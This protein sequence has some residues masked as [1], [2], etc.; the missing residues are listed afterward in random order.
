MSFGVIITISCVVLILVAVSTVLYIRVRREAKLISVMKASGLANFEAGDLD[1]LDPLLNLNDQADLLPYNQSFEF[2]RE[3]LKL[4]RKLGS[5]AFGVVVEAT[6][7][8]ILN[9]EEESTVAV[10]MVK[11]QAD[12]E[13]MKALVMELK[14]MV[15]LG[16]HLN[17]V[18]LLGA[19]TQNIVKRELMVIVEHCKFGNVQNFLIKNRHCFNSE[20][21]EEESQAMAVGNPE[22][23]ARYKNV[24]A[25]EPIDPYQNESS[26]TTNDGNYDQL[27]FQNSEHR[28]NSFS[29]FSCNFSFKIPPEQFA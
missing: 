11:H 18:N 22:Y 21:G 27:S 29:F 8:G 16:K 13:V 5:G 6:A 4:G 12:N 1:A 25:L 10:K 19:V 2:P 3:K 15:H 7:Q 23:F 26:T 20:L 9:Y 24:Y 14:I 28:V 17:V